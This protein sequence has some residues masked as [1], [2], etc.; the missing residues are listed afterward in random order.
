MGGGR[1]S[2]ARGSAGA[3]GEVLSTGSRGT[4]KAG[5]GDSA[6]GRPQATNEGGGAGGSGPVVGSVAVS[7]TATTGAGG[8][9]RASPAPAASAG[10]GV[11]PPLRARTGRV[12]ARPLTGGAALLVLM[13]AEGSEGGG[14]SS[15]GGLTAQG[16]A[17]LATPVPPASPCRRSTGRT[18]WPHRGQ[19]TA[20]GVRGN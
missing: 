20:L 19:A 14:P 6:T 9:T 16:A 3:G 18:G 11:S 12:V 5:G 13:S 2:S 15:A 7:S 17:G 8:L 4:R 10:R 1:A